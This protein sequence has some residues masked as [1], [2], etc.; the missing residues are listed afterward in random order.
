MKK[1][2]PPVILLC[3]AAFLAPLIGGFVEENI[4]GV[5]GIS[6]GSLV[7][8]EAATLAHALLGILVVAAL[9]ITVLKKKVIQIP[10]PHITITFTAFIVLV[11][12]SVTISPYKFVSLVSFAEWTIYAA[13]F[14]G[15]VASAGRGN[16]PKVLCAAFVG[17]CAVAALWGIKEFVAQSD[18]NWRIFST[19]INPNALAGVLVM[20]FFAA[21]GLGYASSR[22]TAYTM[23][24]VSALI[25]TAIW[26][27]ASKGGVLAILVG[28]V[29]L[30]VMVGAYAGQ[31]AG[32]RLGQ[33]FGSLVLAGIFVF[34]AQKLERMSP[35][36]PPPKTAVSSTAPHLMT[37]GAPTTADG[38]APA[39]GNR[40]LDTSG[41][42]EQSAEFRL[43]L[44]KGCFQ[45]IKE[46]PM[47]WGIGTYRFQSAR[48][49]ITTQTQ[50]AHNSILQLAVEANLPAALVFVALL[51]MC[52]VEVFRGSRA[53]PEKQN[54]FRSAIFAALLAALV[55]NLIDSDLYIFG[56]GLG[57]FILLAIGL[58]LSA[59]AIV[60][61]H[62]PRLAKLTGLA[63]AG[64]STVFLVYAGTLQIR[65][66]QF[67]AEL[68]SPNANTREEA[69]NLADAGF[70]LDYRTYFLSALG[71]STPAERKQRLQ[72]SIAVGPTEAAYRL[73]ARTEMET[74]SPGDARITLQ[75]ALKQDPNNLLVLDLLLDID[76]KDAPDEAIKV[77]RQLVA[78]EATPYF[79]TRS[80]PDLIPTQTRDARVFLASKETDAKAKIDLLKPA[81]DGYREYAQRTVPLIVKMASAGEQGAY[82][83][84]KEAKAVLSRAI[85]ASAE[86]ATACKAAGDLGGA[87]W[88]SVNIRQVLEKALGDVNA[89]SSGR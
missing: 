71:A 65:L 51:L 17:G 69:T 43:N 28:V 44:W 52:A 4:Q 74:G 38:P 62:L 59:D 68:D 10:Q 61:E 73:L 42:V 1:L 67:R 26:L 40:L 2:S 49:G 57:F 47:G 48:P 15:I 53:L 83:S 72:E 34:G 22:R 39:A 33:L 5:A 88:A 29:A 84:P 8:V 20:G 6:L 9:F 41:T 80:L 18:P 66:E 25:L 11:L 82:G 24:A 78:V 46:Q 12:F 31:R 21:L 54:L 7:S 76:Q 58:Q 35:A 19:W 45:L 13:A 81:L 85:D 70:G 55:H 77:A 36:P 14:T 56:S 75:Q 86:L 30:F 37:V 79:A 3:I 32:V 89:L 60:P 16:G 64:L 23:L 87:Q 50:L 27:T 63:V